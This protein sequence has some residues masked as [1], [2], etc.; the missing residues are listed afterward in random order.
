MTQ[1]ECRGWHG[2][3]PHVSGPIVF[4]G[5]MDEPYATNGAARAWNSAINAA[6]Y[7][8]PERARP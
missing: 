1:L 6:V 5:Y 2:L 3:W 7:P 8:Q 4:D